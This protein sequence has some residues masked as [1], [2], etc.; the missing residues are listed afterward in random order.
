MRPSMRATLWPRQRWVPCPKERIRGARRATSKR[1]ASPNSRSSRFAQPQRNITFCPA[2]SVSPWS[3]TSSASVRPSIV[4]GISRR[5]ASQKASP[6]PALVHALREVVAHPLAGRLARVRLPALARRPLEALVHG[7]AE[8][9]RVL[10]RDAEDQARDA[11]GEPHPEVAD[12]VELAL[13]ELLV[14]EA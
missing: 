8:Q 1:S 3:R 6:A 12:Q 4:V 11:H 14:E 13:R 9:V 7:A 5:S 2:R 10:E